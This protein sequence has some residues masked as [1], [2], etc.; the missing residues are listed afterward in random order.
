VSASRDMCHVSRH[1]RGQKSICCIARTQT[2][3]TL[4]EPRNSAPD[5]VIICFQSAAD[6]TAGLDARSSVAVTAI[7]LRF[8]NI[9]AEPA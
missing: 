3:I 2:A 5:P 7:I 4:I 9:P 6:G 1:C 8:P